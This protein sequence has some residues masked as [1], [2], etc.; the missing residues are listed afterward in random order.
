MPERISPTIGNTRARRQR[1]TSSN[2][3]QHWRAVPHALNVKMTSPAGRLTSQ[4]AASETPTEHQPQP[5]GQG[6]AAVQM[7]G[8]VE[9]EG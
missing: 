1:P 7:H 8:L 5:A 6:F 2:R 4:V 3:L 9:G